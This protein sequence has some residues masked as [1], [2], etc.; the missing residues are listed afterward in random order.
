MESAVEY[1]VNCS[2]LAKRAKYPDPYQF[3]F[4]GGGESLAEKRELF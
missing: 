2:C 1:I 3:S 4:S